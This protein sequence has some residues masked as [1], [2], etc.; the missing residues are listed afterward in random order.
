MAALLTFLAFVSENRYCATIDVSVVKW[1]FPS[2]VH[3]HFC[4]LIFM[5]LVLLGIF[6]YEYS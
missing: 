2:L 3:L 5:K 6:I 4:I 1:P